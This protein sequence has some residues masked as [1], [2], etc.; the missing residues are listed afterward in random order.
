M[1]LLSKM[2]ISGTDVMKNELTGRMN[3]VIIQQT[4]YLTHPVK[5]LLFAAL[6]GV[7]YQ[8]GKT[9]VK[10]LNEKKTTLKEDDFE[11]CI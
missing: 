10:K 6:V 11:E 8:L 9:A 2:V 1:E 7:S 5:A 4:S 3:R